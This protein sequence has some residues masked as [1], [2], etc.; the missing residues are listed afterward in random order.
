MKRKINTIWAICFAAGIMTFFMP[1]NAYACS[2][3]GPITVEEQ[4]NHSEAVFAGRV[5]EVKE[6]KSVEGYVTKAVLFE[7]KQIWKGGPESQIIIQTGSGG[8]DCGYHFEEGKDYLVYANRSDMYG[9]KEQLVT[10]IC[11]RTKELAGAQ[12]DLTVL[13]EGKAPTEQV[14]LEK[15]EPTEQVQLENER[16]SIQPFVWVALFAIA[17]VSMMVYLSWRRNKVN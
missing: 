16:Q 17:V 10:I 12:E 9:G 1:Q 13:G 4:L 5:L 8:G 2:C 3:A 11:D 15:K 7:T 14:Q 6:Q